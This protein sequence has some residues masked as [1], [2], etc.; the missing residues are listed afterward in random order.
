MLSDP[1]QGLLQAA[2]R[3]V[4]EPHCLVIGAGRQQSAVR[5]EGHTIN[6]AGMALQSLLQAARRRV[7]EPHCQVIGAGCQQPAVRQEGHRVN[8]AGMA[9]QSL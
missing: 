3:R 4:P 1:R 9:L 6:P 5:R 7:P 2:R 8:R